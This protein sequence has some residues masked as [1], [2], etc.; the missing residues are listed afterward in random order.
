MTNPKNT[1]AS[2][3]RVLALREASKVERA[4]T[5]PHHGS[6]SDGQHQYDATMLYLVLCPNPSFKVVKAIMVHDAGERWVGDLPAPAK[7]SDGE[8]A[9]RHEQLERRCLTFLGMNITLT[10]EEG[11]WLKAVDTVELWLWAHEQMALGNANA[12]C[13]I[14]NLT[15]FFMRNSLPPEVVA[16]LKDYQWTRTPDEIPKL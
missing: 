13:I 10:E 16:F 6:Y 15:S 14:G 12:S 8:M 11:M 4:H 5:L 2:T 3:L 1:L 9:K 7:W